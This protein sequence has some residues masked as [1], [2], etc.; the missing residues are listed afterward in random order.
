MGSPA[1]CRAACVSGACGTG[2]ACQVVS[3][4][5]VCV[6]T[7]GAGDAA[8]APCVNGS[9]SNGLTCL[10]GR[11]YPACDTQAPACDACVATTGTSGVCACADQR[12]SEGGA[13]GLVAGIPFA[14]AGN[15]LCVEGRCRL[16][17]GASSSCSEGF[18]CGATARGPACIPLDQAP[19]G[20]TLEGVDGGG[21]GGGGGGIP[22]DTAGCGCTSVDP[23]PAW[24]WLAL[25]L[26]A[27]VRRRPDWR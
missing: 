10:G 3:G 24:T 17:C 1:T 7:G 14:C 26:R 4:R 19:G 13:C 16:P 12:Q 27:A 8:C 22:V 23:V 11:C 6:P 5:S 18:T 20:G 25:A 2:E 9:C 15:G 21:G